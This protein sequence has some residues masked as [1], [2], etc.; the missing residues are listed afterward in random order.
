MCKQQRLK[1]VLLGLFVAKFVFLVVVRVGVAVAIQASLLNGA[2]TWPCLSAVQR[3]RL[4][5][6]YCSPPC[7]AVDG[8]W[9]AARGSPPC[10]WSE[11]LHCAARPY[12]A[13][14]LAAAR[15]RC[16]A[17]L[18]RAL[19]ALLA[20]LQV[21]GREWK[22]AVTEDLALM[23]NLM[24]P[25]LDQQ[26]APQYHLQQWI[27]LAASFPVQWKQ[28]IKRFLNKTVQHQDAQWQMGVR[29]LADDL[30]E[31]ETESAEL[32]QCTACPRTFFR[33]KA[34]EIPCNRQHGKRAEARWFV[35]G[36]VCPT[37]FKDFITRPRTIAHMMRGALSC[38]LPWRT[39]VL[40][41]FTCQHVEE[42]D[43]F[44]RKQRY[45]E[46]K[47]GQL[48]GVGIPHREAMVHEEES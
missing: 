3:R 35:L 12:F 28:L 37:C 32:Y 42:A 46:S 15:L 27:D 14:V 36:S 16:L 10:P 11:V 34:L 22:E 40:P 8:S 6:R 25:L 43:E 17:R 7:R 13:A 4:A 21:A 23:R 1:L 18:Q 31:E 20:L 38:T 26:P 24:S 19:A 44:D 5:V 47:H 30:P 39:G 9:S 48:P 41:Q 29:L 33:R 45:E 2:S